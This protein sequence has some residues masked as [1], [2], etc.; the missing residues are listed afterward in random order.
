VGLQTPLPW[1][2][3]KTSPS[4]VTVGHYP[5]MCP[6]YLCVCPSFMFFPG[7]LGCVLAPIPAMTP[8]TFT[9]PR[10]RMPWPFLLFTKKL[11]WNSFFSFSLSHLPSVPKGDP[12]SNHF[13]FFL[14]PSLFGAVFVPS[15][16][17]SLESF[18]FLPSKDGQFHIKWG[19]S[20]PFLQGQKDL[21]PHHSFFTCPS[22]MSESPPPRDLFAFPPFPVLKSP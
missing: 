10:G 13:L 7:F 3:P 9:I 12:F 16:P 15:F 4:S 19:F 5:P 21:T 11:V 18:F 8:D 17:S 6:N 1:H 2:D 20:R 22:M 14:L